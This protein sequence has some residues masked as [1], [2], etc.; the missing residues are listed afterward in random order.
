MKIQ[1]YTLLALSLSLA[2]SAHAQWQKFDDFEDGNLD[3]WIWTQSD[4]GTT[5][6]SSATIAAD[7]DPNG[8]AAGNNVLV[9]AP[10]S[11][12]EAQH[13]SRLIGQL[14]AP[15][16]YGT[17]GTVFYRWYTK[18]VT[19]D[20]TEFQPAL[21]MNV[22]LSAVD[23]PTQY[24]ESGPVTGYK[25][26]ADQFRAYNGDPN[27]DD[28]SSVI[29]FQNLVSLRPDNIWVSQWFYVRNLSTANQEQD[30]QVY[31]RVGRT[32]TPI[33]AFPLSGNANE[34]GGFRAK[35]D[36]DL[37]P[38][39]AHL[40]VFYFTNSA[41]NIA[42]PQALD[43]F[44]ADDIYVNQ[45]GLDLTDPRGDTGGGDG[46]FVQTVPNGGGGSAPE[47][48][49]MSNISTRG[50]VA[51]AAEPLSPGFVVVGTTN[52]QVLIRAA[53]PAL[54][55]FGV[56]GAL[57]A[58]VIKVFNSSQ[59]QVAENT[60]WGT[61]ENASI[62][63]STAAAVGAFPFASGSADSALLL[64]LEPGSY[65]VQISGV[66]GATGVVVAEVYGVN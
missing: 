29:G 52:Q 9:L 61:A 42:E 58:P 24:N 32:G 46:G 18:T 1:K 56:T 3:K 21:D 26:D 44:Y 4:V 2:A 39:N 63:A 59:V 7:P 27:P 28:P 23:V 33:L 64:S 45:N 35:P 48:T 19:I 51:S 50:T 54:A 37:D 22:G 6:D 20:G 13:R 36:G 49:R 47:T 16:N 40:D 31:Y 34:Y 38:A 60:G 25:R 17:T 53:G 65:T 57:T 10:G 5:A 8:A 30:Y 66:D 14:S 43:D 12:F 62:I 15:I 55:D 11:A 41:G